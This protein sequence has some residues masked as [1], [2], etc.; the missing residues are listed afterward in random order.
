MN[1]FHIV[2]HHAESFSMCLDCIPWHAKT[3]HRQHSKSH[4]DA[5]IAR[6]GIV[7]KGGKVSTALTTEIM[8]KLFEKNR[9]YSRPVFAGSNFFDH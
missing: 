1:S 7:V 2:M 9:V 5:A 8:E 6:G 4:N 3:S